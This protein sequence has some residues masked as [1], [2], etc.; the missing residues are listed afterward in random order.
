MIDIID[1]DVTMMYN[2]PGPQITTIQ[3]L[4]QLDRFAAWN[5]GLLAEI[6]D[7]AGEN[8]RAYSH[9]LSLLILYSNSVVQLLRPLLDLEGFPVE[10]VEDTIR[11][12]AQQGLFFFEEHYQ[13]G[14]T[15]QYQ[16]TLQ[17]FATLHLIDVVARFFP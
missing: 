11:N 2:H 14:Y 10:L 17:M 5:D 7:V 16:P 8:G 1:D 4:Q 6:A 13:L 9:V 15:S 12:H 3:V